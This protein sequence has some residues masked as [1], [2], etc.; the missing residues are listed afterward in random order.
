[1]TIESAESVSEI[2]TAVFLLPAVPSLAG[3]PTTASNGF[4]RS[5]A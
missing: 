3:E 2:V 1:M 4:V 5:N